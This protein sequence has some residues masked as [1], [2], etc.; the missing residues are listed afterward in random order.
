LEDIRQKF[1]AATGG[2]KI[3]VH[4]ILAQLPHALI[5]VAASVQDVRQVGLCVG[6]GKT[7]SF[8]LIK[9]DG[10]SWYDPQNIPSQLLEKM[11][12]MPQ[13][14]VI[15]YI[16]IGPNGSYYIQLASGECWWGVGDND[17]EFNNVMNLVDVYRVAF[18]PVTT[19]DSGDRKRVETSWII[20]T[21]DGRILFRNIPSRLQILLQH[22][23]SHMSSIAEVSLGAAGSYFVRFLDGSVDYLLPTFV[24]DACQ[25]I[26]KQGSYISSLS[27]HPD[28]PNDFIVRHTRFHNRSNEKL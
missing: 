16:S 1:I 3:H 15:Q 28:A 23:P 5:R 7:T 11:K 27:L 4:K 21:K 19:Y 8:Y 22:R 18:G 20:V 6:S 24:A 17:Q 2:G 13:P 9:D 10:S 26:I 14:L 25:A 12:K